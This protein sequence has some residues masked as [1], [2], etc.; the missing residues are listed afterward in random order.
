MKPAAPMSLHVAMAS[1]SNRDGCAMETMIA[2]MIAMKLS[3]PRQPVNQ[4]R[5]SLVLT[6]IV[7]LLGGV[8]MVPRTAL[9]GPMKW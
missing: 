6:D 4:I 2:G 5:I 8:A 1:A 3:V 7:Y 9:M